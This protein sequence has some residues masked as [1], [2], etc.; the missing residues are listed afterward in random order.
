MIT[1]LD[2]DILFISET[3]MR[4]LSSRLGANVVFHI[5]YSA[6]PVFGRKTPYGTAVMVHDRHLNSLDEF[7]LEE[8]DYG[9]SIC[10]SW[11]NILFN[12]VYL[13]PNES[14]F[15]ESFCRRLCKFPSSRPYRIL[16]GDLNMHLGDLTGDESI[17]GRAY[18]DTILSDDGLKRCENESGLATFIGSNGTSHSIV[19]YFYVSHELEPFIVNSTTS[20][21]YT[22]SDHRLIVMDLKVPPS[23]PRS[24]RPTITYPRYRLKK[25]HDLEIRQSYADAIAALQPRL[26]AITDMNS[27]TL[28][29]ETGI[30][31]AATTIVGVDTHTN[32][33]GRL[34]DIVIKEIQRQRRKLYRKMRRT[35]NEAL[36]ARLHVTYCELK[37]REERAIKKA[38]TQ[39]FRKFSDN[40]DNLSKTECG[41]ILRRIKN[42]KL[43]NRIRFLKTDTLSL[44]SYAEYFQSLVATRDF[45][46]SL[47]TSIV[48]GTSADSVSGFSVGLIQ[49]S[50]SRF[51]NGKAGGCSGLLI[52]LL[53]PNALAISHYLLTLFEKIWQEGRVPD[54]WKRALLCP[55]PK[56]GDLKIISNYRPIMLTETFRK[57]FER[58]LLQQHLEPLLKLDICQGG[59]R[60]KRSTIDLIA[61]LQEAIIQRRRINGR[62]PILAFLDIKAAYDTVLRPLL[63]N[64]IAKAGASTKLLAILRSLFDSNTSCVIVNGH[65]SDPIEH[66]VGL[67]QG[68][69]LSPILYAYFIDDLAA[70]LRIKARCTMNSV[71]VGALMYADDIVLIADN[72]DHLTELLQICEAHSIENGYRFSPTKCEILD[73][74]AVSEQFTPFKLYG[75]PI[76]RCESFP[77]LGVCFSNSGMDERLQTAKLTQ[78]FEQS[79]NFYRTIG[80]NGLGLSGNVKRLMLSSF[81]RPTLE[82]GLSLFKG[83][84][85]SLKPFKS[86]FNRALRFM[87]SVPQS[88]PLN[89]MYALSGITPMEI[90]HLVLQAKWLVRV[91]NAPADCLVHHALRENHRHRLGKSCFSRLNEGNPI[92]NVMKSIRRTVPKTQVG[93]GELLQ[94][95]L[96]SLYGTMTDIIFMDSRVHAVMDRAEPVKSRLT[97]LAQFPSRTAA[98]LLTRWLLRRPWGKPTP[99]LNCFG[100]QDLSISHVQL[101][102]GVDIDG[103]CA[104]KEYGTAIAYL[105]RM[106]RH[107]VGQN[108][109]HTVNTS[110][111]ADLRV[112]RTYMKR[113]RALVFADLEEMRIVRP[114]LDRNPP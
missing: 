77:Y 55:V 1:E 27:F 25:L 18:L 68:S 40:L 2:I 110:D 57:I 8:F 4:S 108:V 36:R 37:K 114:R 78:R 28:T 61:C 74:L 63:W 89:N 92:I 56:K 67:L 43:R 73:G 11:R 39:A 52:E 86:V 79:I 45:Q 26:D 62:Y 102:L 84:K 107:C 50:L 38:T 58:C 15:D 64:K 32:R 7:Q 53:K 69:I 41:K 113:Q 51:A 111:D 98:H 44:A 112:I 99:C 81:L 54:N 88:T 6:P 20:D 33:D 95:T 106:Y 34:N 82:Y 13:P 83:T 14:E 17:N 42:S 80:F 22:G 71:K 48:Q 87:F 9:F 91:E 94:N 3:Q 76:P 101:C 96:K 59:F 31:R 97:R 109:L 70:K 29:L 10:W 93:D 90:R 49:Q 104:R 85:I 19:D 60:S 75:N 103:A 105:R 47:S 30:H 23:T 100:S 65:M 16:L 46:I 35:S 12:G 21:Y 66:E 72:E 24:I 5:P